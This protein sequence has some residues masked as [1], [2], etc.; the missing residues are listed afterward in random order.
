PFGDLQQRLNRKGV[1]AKMMQDFPVGIRLYDVLF[2][3]ADDVRPLPFDAR[4]ARLEEWYARVHPR[5][6]D[7]SEQIRFRSLDELTALRDG[8]RAASIEGLMLKRGDSAYVPGRVK[9]LWWK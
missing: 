1:T 3:G 8:A 7:L 9:G 2:D 4:R 6:M 5:R